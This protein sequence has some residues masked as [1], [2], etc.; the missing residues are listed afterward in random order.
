MLNVE[1]TARFVYPRTA[2]RILYL[3]FNSILLQCCGS[4]S[5]I[6]FLF[7]PGSGLGFFPDPNIGF[8]IPNPYFFDSLMTK[9]WIKSTIILSVVPGS[10]INIPDPQH[11]FIFF[12]LI[13]FQECKYLPEHELKQLCDIVCDLLLEESN[14]QVNL[15][16]S[17]NF[18]SAVSAF[19]ISRICPG[20]KGLDSDLVTHEIDIF[21]KS[22]AFLHG[23]FRSG[24]KVKLFREF[25]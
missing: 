17:L 23:V 6:R 20:I 13:L 9:F 7:D 18:K 11:C 3:H 10:E 19:F 16:F 21:K 25:P 2:V 14:I 22:Q 5:G 1:C 12:L 8:R 15:T 24:M 4:G